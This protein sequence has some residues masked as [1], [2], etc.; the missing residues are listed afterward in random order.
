[1]IHYTINH[2]VT[3]DGTDEFNTTVHGDDSMKVWLTTDFTTD[4]SQLS[5]EQPPEGF[6]WETDPSGYTKHPSELDPTEYLDTIKSLL[7]DVELQ[8]VKNDYE[9][10]N[11]TR[12]SPWDTPLTDDVSK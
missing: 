6:R 10:R 12:V 5:I 11:I 9:Q 3:N 2:Y 8:T 7:T 1:M 4:T